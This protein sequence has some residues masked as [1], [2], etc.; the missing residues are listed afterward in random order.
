MQ[1]TP[2]S[3]NTA[4]EQSSYLNS[5]WVTAQEAADMLWCSARM[6]RRRCRDGMYIAEMR[7]NP[8]GKTTWFINPVSLLPKNDPSY[9]TVRE[10][11]LR[12]RISESSVTRRCR[13]GEYVAE[14]R[15]VST[16]L[17]WYIEP[18]SLSKAA[19]VRK[20]G[21]RKPTK[22]PV[23]PRKP[24][25]AIAP[26]GATALKPSMPDPIIEQKPPSSGAI[27]T[28]RPVVNTVPEQQISEKP[29]RVVAPKPTPKTF[30]L[31]HKY[32]IAMSIA[33][34]VFLPVLTFLFLLSWKILM[35]KVLPGLISLF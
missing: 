10:A 28:S 9:I 19:S 24:V 11:A 32:A 27:L 8:S 18:Q 14:L 33:I 3:Y 6:V 31:T 22:I 13:S 30:V 21:A 23:A 2:K 15:N 16:G 25:V 1:P 7:K 34:V 35:D 4:F 5:P 20:V 26:V 12:L 29:Q 17:T